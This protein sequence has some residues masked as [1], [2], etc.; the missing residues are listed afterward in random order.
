MN[1]RKFTTNDLL[2]DP[3][4]IGFDSFFNKI[5]AINR[6]N[7]S[8]YPPYNLIKTGEDTYVIE[9]AVA[10]FKEE[11][12]DIEVHNGV[13]TISANVADTS[14]TET[15]YL[16]KG[17]AARSFT[18]KFTLADTI[19]VKGVSLEKGMLTIELLNVIPEEKKPK[20]IQIVK[21]KELL[22]E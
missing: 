20:K 17:I 15:T 11:D 19:E 4:F 21:S 3:F 13:L 10:G 7:A 12:F 16:H 22:L 2:N 5:D 6:S 1:T 8:N 14:G 18:R 9:L